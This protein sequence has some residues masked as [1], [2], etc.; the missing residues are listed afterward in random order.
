MEPASKPQSIIVLKP[1]NDRTPPDHIKNLVADRFVGNFMSSFKVTFATEN[2]SNEI[3]KSVESIFINFVSELE[4]FEEIAKK[5]FNKN[6]LDRLINLADIYAG[7]IAQETSSTRVFLEYVIPKSVQL[8]EHN[9]VFWKGALIEYY[10]KFVVTNPNAI[11][12]FAKKIYL[13]TT[14]DLDIISEK[15]KSCISYFVKKEIDLSSLPLIREMT[16]KLTKLFTE[17]KFAFNIKS[18]L[19][20][21]YFSGCCDLNDYCGKILDRYSKASNLFNHSTAEFCISQIDDECILFLIMP[22]MQ[23]DK[24]ARKR[25][26]ISTPKCFIT[27]F[28]FND[29]NLNI[30]KMESDND[31]NYV[32]NPAQPS[33][34]TFLAFVDYL[35]DKGFKL[36]S[37]NQ[38]EVIVKPKKMS[39]IEKRL[40]ASPK[41]LVAP[42][43]NTN[44]VIAAP[45]QPSSPIERAPEKSIK[46]STIKAPADPLQELKKLKGSKNVNCL[47]TKIGTTKSPMYRSLLTVASSQRKSERTVGEAP[48]IKDAERLAVENYNN[49]IFYN[50]KKEAKKGSQRDQSKDEPIK[51]TTT[52]NEKLYATEPVM[53]EPKE[54]LRFEVEY[55]EPI[56]PQIKLTSHKVKEL[57]P[58]TEEEIQAEENPKTSDQSFKLKERNIKVKKSGDRPKDRI[59][60]L[61]RPQT[62]SYATPKTNEVENEIKKDKLSFFDRAKNTVKDTLHLKK[63]TSKDQPNED[64]T[65]LVLCNVSSQET[66]KFKKSKK[67]KTSFFSDL[68]STVSSPNFYFLEDH[69]RLINLS[70]TP[71]VKSCLDKRLNEEALATFYNSSLIPYKEIPNE[72]T[73]REV[74]AQDLNGVTGVYIIHENGDEEIKELDKLHKE[75]KNISAENTRL[76]LK[77]IELKTKISESAQLSETEIYVKSPSIVQE[78]PNE[79]DDS[80][81]E[82]S[83]VLNISVGS[84]VLMTLPGET[85]PFDVRRIPYNPELACIRVHSINPNTLVINHIGGKETKTRLA[86]AKKEK[87][88]YLT[89]NK[90][91]K[92]ELKKLKEAQRKPSKRSERAASV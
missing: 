69:N 14:P 83:L 23:L 24:S 65:E 53:I 62:T 26:N 41:Q 77:L 9:K 85:I 87:E 51:P 16:E 32:Y 5:I 27:P 42:S 44:P 70:I 67:S 91:L 12:D 37:Q 7:H 60:I 58:K 78:N 48:S 56:I 25:K 35:E 39:A 46:S 34:I 30:R 22:P 72:T 68:I 45:T 81:I 52:D 57:T 84:S 18:V 11:Y 17:E 82:K 79:S 73:I 21:P 55:N 66:K 3:V 80:T 47:T 49:K 64:S 89:E 43:P 54:P 10:Q 50:P 71:Y 1:E 15:W 19:E 61:N 36:V 88:F 20:S 6:Q 29:I 76:N 92:I 38:R 86:E 28:K 31:K 33:S 90:R 2:F 8:L 75:I 74:F 13:P 4:T 59:T 63:D 40:A